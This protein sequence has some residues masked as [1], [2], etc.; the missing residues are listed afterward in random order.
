MRAMILRRPALIGGYLALYIALDWMSLI[1][2]S[3]GAG[4]LG[5]TP[6][7]PPAGLSFA[8]LLRYGPT[9]APAVFAAVAI[10]SVLF[11]G[12][13]GEPLAIVVPALIIAMVYAA[14]AMMLRNRFLISI[15]LR[16]HR[17][18]LTLLAVALVATM[19][20]AV[21]VVAVFAVTGLLPR[22]EF[23][24]FALHFWV[25]DMI[26]IAG[27]TPLALLMMDP[28]Q[29]DRLMH[30]FHPLEY[31]LQLGAVAF[32][33]WIIFGWEPTDHFEYSYVLFLPLIWIG[34][35]GGLVGATW[36]T[37][38]TQLG[39]VLAIQI[40]G[41]DA[42]VT[43]QF[44][45]LML[46]VAVTGLVLGSIVDEE[47]R[48]ESSLRDS[49]TRL[50]TVVETAPDAILTF[51]ETGEITSANPAAE[52]M[53]SATGRWP[54]GINIQSLLAGLNIETP[55][56]LAGNEMVARRL[57]DTAF[58]AEVAVGQAAVGGRALYVAAVRD[59]SIRKQA[60]LW[61]K[62]HETELAHASRLTATGEMAASLAHELNQPL[63]ALI[64]FARACQALL[65][66]SG[67]EDERSRKAQILIEQTVQ[68]A[69]RAG[70]IIRSTREFLRRGD[71]NVTKVEVAQIFKAVYD[72]VKSEA[73]LNHVRVVIRF[74]REIPPVL[75]DAIQVE[76]VILNLIRNSMEAMADIPV[77]RREIRLSAA[78]D[79]TEP[80]FVTI[81]V[82]DTGP[83]FATE[84][85]DGMF[86]PFST[87]KSTGMGLG[88]SISRSIIEAHGGRI[89]SVPAGHGAEP[90]ADIRF[91]LPSYTDVKGES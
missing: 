49:E 23:S 52:R 36:G 15:R 30:G 89:W 66:S 44:Q 56:A 87:T 62:E 91:T 17:D 11:H 3:G 68:Q 5:I 16:T 80:G 18:L 41:F 88:L 47:Q 64:S 57:N 13:S 43:T 70:D 60:E 46:A 42:G 77:E 40:K 78:L 31:V 2:P 21:S 51:D 55:D 7:N 8:L 85:E 6:W 32:G 73:S 48:A 67:V 28:Q 24:N 26:G 69:L 27:F 34:L 35:R 90:G 10:S 83:G 4:A 12:L 81:A 75:A 61:L 59:I 84:L 45:L 39:L 74:E 22:P 20:V 79:P 76:Q 71:A 37:L 58:P 82:Q 72:L 14:A 29:R 50:Q 38:A 63:T 9:F 33:L 53:F 65:K 1:Q 19:V 25:G 86:K 54:V